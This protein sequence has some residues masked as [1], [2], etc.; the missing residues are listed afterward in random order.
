[1]RLSLPFPATAGATPTPRENQLQLVPRQAGPDNPSKTQQGSLA[2]DLPQELID[3]YGP[4]PT[5]Q[6]T[7]IWPFLTVLAGLVA[8]LAVWFF[9]R[10]RS[11]Q[12]ILTTSW[13]DALLA[14]ERAQELRNPAQGQQYMAKASHILRRYIEA[15][16][17][18]H[19]TRQTTREFLHDIAQQQ[20]DLLPYRE[21]LQRCLENADLAKFA[22]R[23]ADEEMLL[24]MEDSVADFIRST[25]PIPASSTGKIGRQRRAEEGDT[26]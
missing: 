19:S 16:F 1:M 24:A 4:L 21:K 23:P 26:Q 13:E 12:P 25:S 7:P 22:H 11:K 14:L 6:A 20:A 15:R 18:I 8:G 2:T 9:L 10:Q 3:I 5:P 17:A